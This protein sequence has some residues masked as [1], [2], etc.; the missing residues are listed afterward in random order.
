MSRNEEIDR[1]EWSTSPQEGSRAPRRPRGL[2]RPGAG[3]PAE[4]RQL[5]SSQ[6]SAAAGQIGAAGQTA[7]AGLDRARALVKGGH[8]LE[9][10][11]VLRPLVER[12]PDRP[13]VLFLVGFAGIEASRQSG[14]SEPVRDALLDAAIEALHTMLVQ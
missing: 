4:A 6:V 14:V 8:F 2:R 13:D 1:N 10:L 9:A 11:K 7:A 12:H 3:V 5:P